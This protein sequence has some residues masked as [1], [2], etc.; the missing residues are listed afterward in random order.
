MHAPAVA[1]PPPPCTEVRR[2]R[3][4]WPPGPAFDSVTLLVDMRVED[5]WP[6]TLGPFGT[7]TGVL[8][9]LARDGGLDPAPTQV[10]PVGLRRARLA[11]R[12]RRTPESWDGP[13]AS[14]RSQP[15]PCY[16]TAQRRRHCLPVATERVRTLLC[17][18]DRR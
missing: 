10:G 2:P 7:T 17:V 4:I 12:P 14:P 8:V 1:L 15:E 18:P 3:E 6:P 9:G 16:V 11:T 13:P 5:R